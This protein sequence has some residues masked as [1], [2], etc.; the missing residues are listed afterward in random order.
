[1]PF[2]DEQLWRPGLRPY[3]SDMAL[4]AGLKPDKLGQYEVGGKTYIRLDGNAYEKTFDPMLNK[5][6]LKHPTAPDAYLP[7]S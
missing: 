5:W 2:G 3:L 1:M 7:R 4:P 6:R